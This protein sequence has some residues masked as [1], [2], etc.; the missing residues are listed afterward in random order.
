LPVLGIKDS[1]YEVFARDRKEPSCV[2]DDILFENGVFPLHVK[3]RLVIADMAILVE[4]EDET[5][6]IDLPVKTG[7][8]AVTV[9]GFRYIRNARVDRFGFEFC[10]EKQSVL[11]Q[12]TQT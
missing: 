3:Q 12:F 5:A 1:T 7:N 11:P 4:W 8:Y 2:E 9:R 10:F 6:W